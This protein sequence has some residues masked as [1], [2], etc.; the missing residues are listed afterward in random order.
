MFFFTEE[1]FKMTDL[2]N[3]AA[4]DGV[5]DF[6]HQNII[7]QRIDNIAETDEFFPQWY[8]RNP[9]FRTK[10]PERA[11]EIDVLLIESRWIALQTLTDKQTVDLFHNHLPELFNLQIRHEIPED[12]HVVK[13][14]LTTKIRDRV[15]V[16]LMF[17]ERDKFKKQLIDAI[18]SSDSE[19]TSQVFYRGIKEARPTVKHWFAEYVEFLPNEEMLKIKQK[20]FFAKNENYKR[21][22]DVEKERIQLLIQAYEQLKI[23][24]WK[25][26]GTEEAVRYEDEKGTGVVQ[27]GN[28][29]YDD[30][31][32]IKSYEDFFKMKEV[33][34]LIKETEFFSDEK[35]G[36]LQSRPPVSETSKGAL[37]DPTLSGGPDIAA[38]A[39]PDHFTT[40][41]AAD[42]QKLAGTT[43]ELQ[44]NGTNYQQQ[45]KQLM[46]TLKLNFVT[47]EQQKKFTMLMESVLRGLRDHMELTTYLEDMQY[48]QPEIDAILQTVK[49]AVHGKT[50][51]GTGMSA[52][53]RTDLIM[54]AQVQT[55]G[56]SVTADTSGMATESMPDISMMHQDNQI[57]PPAA[58][59]GKKSFLPKLRRSRRTKR[60][61]VDDVKIQQSMVM[62]PIDEL[63]AMDIVEFRRLSP[64]PVA[65]AGKL[66]DK[67]QLLGQEAISKQAEG[68]QAFRE[69]ILNQMYIEIGNS[70]IASGKAVADLIAERQSQG[71][72]TLSLNEFNAIADLN[73][74]L[75]F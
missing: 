72:I 48:S 64:D 28:V 17:D 75:R 5:V 33:Q 34:D 70:S 65:A 18:V 35:Y 51:S 22:N 20:E 57:S 37:T 45:A 49:Q 10:Y 2:A 23:S 58:D 62:G 61:L 74:E 8:D 60:P 55:Q 68:V 54:P 47:P 16:N 27:Y 69:S 73:K 32:L 41:D 67:I 6:M 11:A 53:L 40:Q 13:D 25:Q 4:F 1:N 30:P 9:E 31:E 42:V 63:H 14:Y 21:L 26:E 66:K 52:E 29:E 56:K 38:T 3:Q 12:Q 59:T 46:Q 39:G 43:G 15:L 7:F 19:I 36:L 24:S 44:T 71:Q 50:Q